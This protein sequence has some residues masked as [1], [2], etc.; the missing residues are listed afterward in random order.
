MES[1]NLEH[2]HDCD[3]TCITFVA[4]KIKYKYVAVLRACAGDGVAS[5]VWPNGRFCAEQE[6]GTMVW[7]WTLSLTM[8]Q[9]V[10]LGRSFPWSL[11]RWITQTSGQTMVA[12]ILMMPTGVTS[13]ETWAWIQILAVA[14]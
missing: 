7:K 13:I 3:S 12:F 4:N 8:V 14:R 1:V 10:V 9:S 6:A 11:W 2:N 5:Y